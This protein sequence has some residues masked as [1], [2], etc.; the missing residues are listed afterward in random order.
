MA[1][2]YGT[3][4]APTASATGT[5]EDRRSQYIAVA[6]YNHAST[7]P[8]QHRGNRDTFCE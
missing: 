2:F 5:W 8:L 7:V 1:S 4:R 6:D 3:A